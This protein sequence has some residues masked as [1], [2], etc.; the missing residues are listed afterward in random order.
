M[1]E[2]ELPEDLNGEVVKQATCLRLNQEK[3]EVNEIEYVKCR[4]VEG[5][6]LPELYFENEQ[7]VTVTAQRFFTA[8]DFFCVYDSSTGRTVGKVRFMSASEG[9]DA[10]GEN[11]TASIRWTMT[12]EDWAAIGRPRAWYDL[13][14]KHND[15]WYRLEVQ[16]D[17]SKVEQKDIVV[18]MSVD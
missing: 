8:D 16:A 6:L 11:V 15:K 3:R 14:I 5:D 13:M 7:N 2:G 17:N 1:A 12:D 18:D 9:A 10:S 4:W